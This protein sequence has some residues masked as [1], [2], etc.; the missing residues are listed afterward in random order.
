MYSDVSSIFKRIN[1]S[2]GRTFGALIEF[3]DGNRIEPESIISLKLKRGN[4][5]GEDMTFG[6][7]FSACFDAVLVYDENLL[8][9]L[10]NGAVV[11]LSLGLAINPNDEPFRDFE[12]VPMGKF[13]VSTAN[14]SGNKINCQFV[15]KLYDSDALYKSNLEFPTT[16]GSVL[17][18]ICGILGIS[19]LSSDFANSLLMAII[20]KIPVNNAPENVTCRQMLSFLGAYIAK[21]V[22]LNREGL[23]TF[24]SYNFNYPVEITAD[25]IETPTFGEKVEITAFTCVVNSE[26]TYTK[27]TGRSMYFATPYM[28]REYFE[29]ANYSDITYYPCE[30][31]MLLGNILLDYDVLM[32]EDKLIPIMGSE[33]NFDGGVSLKITSYG[34]TSEEAEKIPISATDLILKQAKKLADDMVQHASDIMNG[35]NGGYRVEKYSDDGTPYATLWMNAPDEISATNCI[36]INKSGV[37]FGTKNSGKTEWKFTQAWLIDGTFNTEFITAHSLELTGKISDSK[38][39]VIDEDEIDLHYEISSELTTPT[40]NGK[41][42][43]AAGLVAYS[44]G[45]MPS[46]AWYTNWGMLLEHPENEDDIASLIVAIMA[47]GGKL[48]Y[49]GNAGFVIVNGD[50]SISGAPGVG[51]T[52]NNFPCLTE[53]TG[54]LKTDFTRS[55]GAN[56]YQCVE[57][58]S[59]GTTI[60]FGTV[61]LN[62]TST[63]SEAYSLTNS[64]DIVFSDDA[65]YSSNTMYAIFLTS[66]KADSSLYYSNQ[67]S[68]GFTINTNSSE[69]IKVK[70]FTIGW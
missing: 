26:T 50:N 56:N 59:T 55:Y 12:F 13:K 67:S 53:E 65:N 39:G 46:R 21:D 68:S 58:L 45:V 43:N 35:V 64:I 15:D 36:M 31:N 63:P 11:N 33:L 41:T 32:Y 37:A 25:E 66:N 28:T 20:K 22:Y 61:T 5:N 70:W 4:S 54:I 38:K 40:F 69:K 49:I 29:S 51:F 10:T 44:E 48:N 24:N 57:K 23:L 7:V 8:K 2:P 6:N 60:Q 3:A 34:K 1:S 17:T 62:A 42:F 14:L 9:K 27:G 18:E 47:A 52:V 16:Y 30:I 19:G